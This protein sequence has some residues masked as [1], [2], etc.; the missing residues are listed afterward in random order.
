M[1][2]DKQPARSWLAIYNTQYLISHFPFQLSL[3]NQNTV[4]FLARAL[5]NMARTIGRQYSKLRTD[6]VQAGRSNR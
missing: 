1:S 6:E 5:V 4:P 3:E 2:V